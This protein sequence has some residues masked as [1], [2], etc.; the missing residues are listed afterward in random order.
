MKVVIAGSV[1]EHFELDLVLL[2]EL[3]SQ[4]K[5][6][7]L[8]SI[9]LADVNF[10]DVLLEFNRTMDLYLFVSADNSRSRRFTLDCIKSS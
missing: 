9:F 1:V 3:F 7:L 8:S 5:V 4:V 6:F 2:T 10:L